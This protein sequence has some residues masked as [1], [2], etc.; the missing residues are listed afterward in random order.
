MFCIVKWSILL[1]KFE[2]LLHNQITK[3]KETFFPLTPNEGMFPPPP[4]DDIYDGIE[5]EEADDG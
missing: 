3:L 1:S 2:W 4:E 5:E